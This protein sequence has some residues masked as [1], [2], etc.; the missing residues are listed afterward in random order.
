MGQINVRLFG[1]F[2]LKDGDG[3]ELTLNTRKTRGLLAFLITQADSWHTRERLAGLLWSD[4]QQAQARHSLTQALSTIRK[5]GEAAGVT[6][7]ESDSDRVRLLADAVSADTL[8]FG[9]NLDRDAAK[10]AAYYTGPFLDGFAA[11]DAAFD[12]WLATERSAFHEQACSALK[13]AIDQ[14]ETSGDMSDAV[15]AAKRWVALDPFSEQ[16]HRRLMQLYFAAGDRAEAIRQYQACEKLLREELG[17]DPSAETK[18]LLSDARGQTPSIERRVVAKPTPTLSQAEATD[19]PDRASIA[20]LPFANL[21][22]DPEQEYFADGITEDIITALSNVR[23]F[24]VLARNSTFAYKCKSVDAREVG[25]NLKA[26]YLIEGSVRRAGDRVRV[27]AQLIHS[28]TGDHLWANRY[29]GKLDDIFDLQD[30]MTSAIVGT[31]EPELVRAEG[32]RL[33][34]K[35]PENLDAYDYLLRGLAYMHKVTPEDTERGLACFE[36]AIELDPNYARAYAFASWCYRREV[37][38]SGLAS[39]SEGDRLKAIDF[40]RKAL[41]CDRNDP[42]VLVY[43]AATFF[44]IEADYDEALALVERAISM[45]P[46]S[47][48]FWNGKALIHAIKGDTEQAIDAAERA[49]SVG[50]NDPAIWNSYLSLAQANLQELRF[51]Q[52]GDFARRALRHNENLGPAYY[53]LAAASAHLGNEADAKQALA[54]ALKINPGMTITAFPKVY[55]VAL[56]KNLDAYLDGL[57]KAGLPEDSSLPM[58]DKPS[59]AVLPFTN[60]SGD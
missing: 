41:Q 6:L 55:H 40:A 20:V 27:T 33:Q 13:N 58:P 28:E 54:T 47:H 24:A 37:E 23:T 12:E 25:R 1:G 57:R 18:A 59:I 5:L 10:A 34:S 7:I 48:R 30:Q 50:P 46:Y 17:V 35:P 4:R 51:M 14:D 15:A 38:Q 56:Y 26:N 8:S 21:S 29:D 60:L 2:D 11:L 49:I 53:L 9:G 42:F 19:L 39:L 36:R 44:M 45:H 3:K 16:A 32:L 31:I 52:A 22:G 43:A